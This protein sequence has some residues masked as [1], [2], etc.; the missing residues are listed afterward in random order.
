MPVQTIKETGRAL[1]AVEGPVR[2]PV[3]LEAEDWV[4]AHRRAIADEEPVF[5][6]LRHYCDDRGWSLMNLLNGVMSAQGQINF[7]CQY[8]GVIKGWHRHTRQTDFWLCAMGHIKA[9][10]FRERDGRAWA[11]VLGEK[12]PGVLIIPPTLWHGAAT[13]GPQPAGLLYYVTHAFDRADPDED[14][15]AWNSVAGFN[16]QVEHR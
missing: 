12:S 5:V 15:R 10:I 1:D 13:V 9:G 2:A 14:R 16:W 3:A 8:P 6:R 4:A 11:Q 7:S